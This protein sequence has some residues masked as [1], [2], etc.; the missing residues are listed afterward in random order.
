M[1]HMPETATK[2]DQEVQGGWMNKKGNGT[3]QDKKKLRSRGYPL[4]ISR[5]DRFGQNTPGW[6]K[7]T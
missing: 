2:R 7:L 1:L 3:N 4:K 5:E 6:D